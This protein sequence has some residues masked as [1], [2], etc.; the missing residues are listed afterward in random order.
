M[1]VNKRFD[2]EVFQH[3]CSTWE[4][5]RVKNI[6]GISVSEEGLNSKVG[7]LQGTRDMEK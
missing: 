7:R 6:R 4:Q 1:S 3:G 2:D 5:P